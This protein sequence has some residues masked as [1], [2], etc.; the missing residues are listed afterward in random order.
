MHQMKDQILEIIDQNPRTYHYL[1]K[2]DSKILNWVKSNSVAK[3]DHLPTQI[4]SAVYGETNICQYGNVKKFTRISTGFSACG[5]ASKCKCTKESI[6][7]SVGKAKSQYSNTQR[8]SINNIRRKTMLDKYGVEYNSQRK[9][10]KHIWSKPKIPSTIHVKLNSLDWLYEQYVIKNRSAV[11]IANELDVY[12]S[13]VIEYCKKHGFKIKQRS[14]YSRTEQEVSKFI[15]SIGFKVET[16]VR[17]I[18]KPKEID[19]YVEEKNLAIEINGLYWHSYDKKNNDR[20]DR[21]RHLSKTKQAADL[22]VD[23]IHITDWE[24]QNKHDIVKSIIMSKL[25]INKKIY[26]RQTVCKQVESKTARKFLQENHIQGTCSSAAYYGL[27]YDKVL[28]MIASVGKNRFKKSE[29][30][31]H[32]LATLKGNTVVGGAGKL[33]KTIGKDFDIEKIISY[34]DRDKSNGKMYKSTGFDLVRETG[35]GYFW[36]DGSAV[37][38]RYRCQKKNLSKWLTNFDPNLSEAENLFRAG[39]RRY[40]TCGNLVFEKH[41]R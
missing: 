29:I 8:K 35:P 3:T 30:E 41:M 34:C 7:Q 23:L 14:R 13:T 25:G 31:L 26:A 4:Y 37:Y 20:E 27:Y 6:S 40:W 38:S 15:E 16:N 21:F 33:L 18:I 1:I 17:D 28:Y 9:D 36:T 24:W 19:I 22:D 12:Y 2:K 39:Y 5:P 11:D 10:I 32:R